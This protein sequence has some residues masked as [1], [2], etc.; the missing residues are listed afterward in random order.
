MGKEVT[1]IVL[2][3]ISVDSILLNLAVLEIRGLLQTKRLPKFN[4]Y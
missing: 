3:Y 4:F 2:D 1:A